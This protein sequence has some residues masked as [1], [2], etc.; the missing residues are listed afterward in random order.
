MHLSTFFFGCTYFYR[1]YF[2]QLEVRAD[3]ET[4]HSVGIEEWRHTIVSVLRECPEAQQFLEL[5]SKQSWFDLTGTLLENG[6]WSTSIGDLMQPAMARA[7]KRNI[8]LFNT[9]TGSVCVILS[10]V[11]SSGKP[12]A[13]AP[14]IV[15]YDETHF[16]V[17][18][19]ASQSDIQCS[20]ELVASAIGPA[21][22]TVER[23]EAEEAV[24]ANA[25]ISKAAVKEV[26]AVKLAAE[27]T[28]AWRLPLADIKIGKRSRQGELKRSK[29]AK[30]SITRMQPY[31]NQESNTNTNADNKAAADNLTACGKDGEHQQVLQ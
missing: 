19:P 30:E 18:L 27:K 15:F 10:S 11:F 20:K 17:G 22:P 7:L 5:K 3:F 4:P 2:L 13:D 23:N 1:F 21:V 14:L 26:H 6:R 16:E 25:V 29:K 9:K 8:L 24:I 28:G 12:S 31:V